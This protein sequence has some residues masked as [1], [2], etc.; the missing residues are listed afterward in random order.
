MISASGAHA[1]APLRR[2]S[3]P[4]MLA[5]LPLPLPLPLTSPLPEATARGYRHASPAH[6]QFFFFLQTHTHCIH[7][8]VPSGQGA[9][10]EPKSS[11]RSAFRLKLPTGSEATVVKTYAN[12]EQ[13]HAPAGSRPPPLEVSRPCQAATSALHVGRP[14]LGAATSFRGA[15]L[16]PESSP[17]M[18]PAP[19]R[20]RPRLS[21]GPAMNKK[22]TG[23][24]DTGCRPWHL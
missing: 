8:A 7:S 19:L 24:G 18:W 23:H 10:A 9:R 21:A 11:I 5:P 6:A 17:A 13:M 4:F 15:R 16:A 22:V 2:P 1:G 12:A 14:A 20:R 3:P